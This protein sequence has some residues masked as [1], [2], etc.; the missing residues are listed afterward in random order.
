[1]SIFLTNV[2]FPLL[3]TNTD[4]LLELDQLI[5]KNYFFSPNAHSQEE[6]AILAITNNYIIVSQ[7]SL[8][9]ISETK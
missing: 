1:M 9:T 4:V 5:L 6:E 8:S 2:F 7:V 3:P